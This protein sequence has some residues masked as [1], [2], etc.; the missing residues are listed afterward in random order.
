LTREQ[1]KAQKKKDHQ[2]LYWLKVKIQPIMDQIKIKYKKFRFSV[3]DTNDYPYLY[4]TPDT[5]EGQNVPPVTF[6]PYEL[7]TDKNGVQGIKEAASG[8]FYYNLNTVIV[9]ERLSNGYYKRPKDYLFDIR[10]LAKDS[11]LFGDRDRAIKANEMLANVEVDIGMLEQDPSLADCENVYRREK[12]REEEL[13]KKSKEVA[14]DGESSLLAGL[15]VSSHSTTNGHTEPA[16]PSRVILSNGASEN[17][18]TGLEQDTIDPDVEMLDNPR[19]FES[20]QETQSTRPYGLSTTSLFRRQS[21][22][23]SVTDP[24][25]QEPSQ[26]SQKLGFGGAVTLTPIP[27]GSQID[28]FVVDASTTAS[29][30]RNSGQSSDPPTSGSNGYHHVS[31]Q[32]NFAGFGEKSEGYSQLTNTQGK[33]PSI[34]EMNIY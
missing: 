17:H 7:D 14:P 9:E 34:R 26:L 10:S 6:R 19:Q 11:K 20:P 23:P 16:T 18:S 12:E 33:L 22:L 28:D 3:I 21:D 27:K 4:A 2:L 29:E 30:K 5:V 8:K 25:S 1:I 24:K 15:G 13:K 32:P 31:R